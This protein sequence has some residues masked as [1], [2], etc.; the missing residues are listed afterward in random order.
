MDRTLTRLVL[1]PAQA[2]IRAGASLA[3]TAMGYDAAGHGVGDV[4][5]QTTFSIH[6][7]GSCTGTSCTATKPGQHTISGVVQLGN[8]VISDTATL[9]V[10]A[11]P[12]PVE[13]TRGPVEP[14]RGPV[15]PSR[16]PVAPSR[17]QVEPRRGP[18]E[19]STRS[20]ASPRQQ[21]GRPQPLALLELRP[22][23]AFLPSGD[24]LD[25]TAWLT[26]ADGNPQDVTGQTTF[27]IRFSAA[28]TSRQI[29]PDGSCTGTSCT[30][31][32]LGRHTVTGTLDL[33]DSTVSG[34]AA[35][36]VVPR[37]R[38]MG[39]PRPMFR[40]RLEPLTATI[41]LHKNQHYTAIATARDGSEHDVTVETT[42]TFEQ[43]D[44]TPFGDCPDAIC[45]PPEVGRYT[46]TG[47]FPQQGGR[48][49]TAT[50]TLLVVFTELTLEPST[51]TIGLHNSQHYRAFANDHLEVTAGTTFTFK[52]MGGT[53]SGPCPD[54][55][56]SP[57]EVGR[58]TIT[59]IFPQPDGRTLTAEANLLVVHTE[60]RLEPLAA[61]IGLDEGGQAYQAFADD[62]YDVTAGTTFTFEQE[63]GTPFG[64]CP[65]AICAPPEVGRY[66]IT[67]TFPQQGGRT[68]TAEATLL[69]LTE[70]LASLELHPK[71]NLAVIKSGGKVTYSVHGLDT[72]GKHLDQLGD[73]APF[74]SFKIDP[75]GGSCTGQICTATPIGQYRVT[76]T[77][78]DD[79]KISGSARLL[80]VPGDI[81]SLELHS[82]PDPA[83]IK[84][85]GKV[86]YSVH[87]LDTNGKHLDQLG[88]LAPFSSF[89]IDPKGG[90]CTGHT[91][92]ATPLG[93]YTV[94]ATLI[95]Q[96]GP[97][98]TA[99]ATLLV[100]PGDIGSLELRPKPNP[101]VIQPGGKVTYRVQG[102]DTGGKHL[103]QL[104][105]LAP[106][107]RFKIDGGGSCTGAT[108]SA[109]KIGRHTVSATL[110]VGDR[111][112]TGKATLRVTT[113]PLNC[114]PSASDVRDLR[115]TP[116]K[117]APETQVQITAKL[118]RTFAACPLTI[119][120]GGS[121]L[122]GNATVGPDGSI[123][124][125]HTVPKGAEPGTT[126]VRLATTS[127]Q[128]LATTRFEVILKARFVAWPPWEGGLPWLLFTL[129]LLLLLVLIPAFFGERERRQRRWARQHVRAEPH[130]S[131]DDVTVDHDPKSA[132]TFS[133]RLQPHGDAGTQTLE[134]GD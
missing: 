52:K 48:T 107:T 113:T 25:Y 40:L 24:S 36:Q 8:R 90:S 65:D 26:A 105:D 51:A 59:G 128:T 6:P 82:T 75:K 61:T 3:Y 58:Y 38:R 34:T 77:L 102:L 27:S 30:A 131:S 121:R 63:D 1:S 101:A 53:L 130:P 64:D 94:T 19:P 126:T 134:E 89:K 99:E 67:G 88:D 73:L 28:K 66:T 91:C 109:T 97:T 110:D 120:F 76:A 78:I 47:T 129:G 74:S 112:I 55:I 35:L 123:S 133:V 57:P 72:N 115:V 5:A 96:D 95:Q 15:D 9:Q 106:F 62:I 7:D 114:A 125:S 42:F 83:V 85:G 39:R 45:A 14:T 22:G 43:E 124:E 31:T 98:L 44:G 50:A 116:G 21:A 111:H 17:R 29:R 23:R 20:A 12:G 49:L 68:L 93:Q 122:G 18:V 86:T 118:K 56:C 92:I 2:S 70:E 119:F 80:V 10:V 37:H 87:G 33:G 84:S 79:P 41:G 69:V 13:P 81:A 103:D 117:G 104:G 16:G 32:K 100:V 127:G 46:I 71:P 108:C 54:A 11:P 4:T 60:L 132:P